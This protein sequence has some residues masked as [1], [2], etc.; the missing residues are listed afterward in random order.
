MPA[1]AKRR[2]DISILDDWRDAPSPYWLRKIVNRAL[3]HVPTEE[4]CQIGLVLADDDTVRHLNKE[5]RGLDELT[6]V[7]SFSP[8]HQGRWQGEGE[9]LRKFDPDVSFVL[10]PGEPLH[11]GEVIISYPQAV[12]QATSG[13]S[14]LEKELAHLVVHGVMHL[15]GFDHEE[16]HE[17][18]K[19]GAKEREILSAIFA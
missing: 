15:A 13:R 16:P 18:S 8:V 4:S 3:D 5:Y 14:S 17:E 7:L 11:L 12:R 19:M 1:R 9:P 2:V 10:P 6:D